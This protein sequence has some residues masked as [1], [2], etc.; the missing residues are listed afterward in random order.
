MVGE[1][2]CRS[3]VRNRMGGC[4]FNFGGNFIFGYFIKNKISYAFP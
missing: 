3:D 1:K 2:G 4:T